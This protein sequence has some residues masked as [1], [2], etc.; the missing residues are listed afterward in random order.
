MKPKAS[1]LWLL[2]LVPMALGLSRLRFD[3][4]VLNLLPPDSPVVQGLKLYQENF[5]NARELILTVRAANAEA[6]ETSAR[7]LAAALR[8]A[9]NL[10]SRVT[11]EPAW[12][13]HPEQGAE[14]I[15]YF[16]LNQPSERFS[17]LTN[18]LAPGNLVRILT[19]AR[20]QLATSFS[21]LE[22]ARGGYDPYGLLQLPDSAL[23]SAPSFGEGEEL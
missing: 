8:R 12:L 15:A 17:E 14:L 13:E 18:R 21:P 5:S 20:E 19:A 1:W 3:V 10:V 9:T 22:I 2:L 6:A 16:W 4:E 23:R 11:W 7:A